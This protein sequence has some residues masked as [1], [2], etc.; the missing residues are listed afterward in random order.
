MEYYFEYENEM[1]DKH[2]P[3]QKE[4]IIFINIMKNPISFIAR[5]LLSDFYRNYL[6]KFIIVTRL[7]I[8]Q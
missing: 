7:I 3:K 8:F 5:D 2:Y 1:Y 4:K 6:I